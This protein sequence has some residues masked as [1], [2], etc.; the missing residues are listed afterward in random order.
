MMMKTRMTLALTTKS[1]PASRRVKGP[2]YNGPFAKI[3]E[4]KNDKE[5]IMVGKHWKQSEIDILLSDEPWYDRSVIELLPGRSWDGI[6]QKAKKLGLKFDHPCTA[7]SFGRLLEATPIS[8]YWNGFLLADGSFQE[9]GALTF[10][11]GDKE[12]EQMKRFAI[13]VGK[14]DINES[15]N[16]VVIQSGRVSHPLME[17]FDYK[18]NKTKHPPTEW[19]YK[20]LSDELLLSHFIG[21]I[22]GDGSVR[23]QHNGTD[24][25]L[26]TIRMDSSWCEWLKEY[27]GEIRKRTGLLFGQPHIGYDGYTE[28]CI[29]SP[30]TV[31]FL[32]RFLTEHQLPVLERKWDKV[33]VD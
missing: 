32:K 18:P 28:F 22:D 31:V 13:F 15:K 24:H 19:D 16:G 27:I 6:K 4:D 23:K 9:R 30:K 26:V 1:Q 14:D 10:A 3:W 21:F 11:L 20:G 12:V 33:E 17:K 29:G 25:C 5:I 8:Y 7:K 2:L